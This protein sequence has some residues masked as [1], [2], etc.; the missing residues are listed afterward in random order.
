M[1]ARALCDDGGRPVGVCIGGFNLLPYRRQAWRARRLRCLVQCAVAV[2]AG[3]VAAALYSMWSGSGGETRRAERVRLESVL[4]ELDAPLAQYR[5]L[6]RAQAQALEQRE[7]VARLVRPRQAL[8]ELVDTLG[9]EPNAGVVLRRLDLT[10][11]GLELKASASD[12]TVSA[13]WV[14]RLG[15]LSGVASAEI[16]DLR[17]SAAGGP[18]PTDFVARL[19]WRDAVSMPAGSPPRAGKGRR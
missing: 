17:V 11:D 19:V 8:F 10:K 2:L 15:R 9:R 7:L 13:S 6:E 16:A 4:A 5:R 3:F 14:E 18:Y 1:I 12:S